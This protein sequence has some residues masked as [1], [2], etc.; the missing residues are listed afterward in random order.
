MLQHKDKISV[1]GVGRIGSALVKALHKADYEIAGVIDRDLSL[2]SKI[3]KRLKTNKF[4]NKILDLT[5]SDITFVAVP[6]DE[7]ADVVT[8][9]KRNFED[10]KTSPFVFH[11][12]GALT[13]EVFYPLVKLNVNCA[14][15]HPIQSFPGAEN[16]WTKFQGIYFGL[17]GSPAAIK[18]ASEIVCKLKGHPIIISKEQKSLYHLACTMASNYLISLMIPVTEIFGNLNF[19]E[20]ESLKIIYPLL[21]TTLS[22]MKNQQIEGALTGPISRGDTGTIE[23]HLEV[24]SKN[25][26]QYKKLYRSMGGILINL[27][28]VINRVS[29]DKYNDMKKLLNGEGLKNG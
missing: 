15:I 17:E 7:I 19:S 12:S 28:S 9:L 29:N 10:Q 23:K 21:M 16:D 3:A 4:S 22:N 25:F 6:D 14:S 18:K 26:P 8:S 1:I 24:L 27:K 5:A 11:T 20:K 2:A 13:S